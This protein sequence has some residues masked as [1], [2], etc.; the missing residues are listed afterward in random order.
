MCQHLSKRAKNSC[1]A[2][3]NS[4]FVMGWSDC[5]HQETF[6]FPVTHLIQYCASRC[7]TVSMQSSKLAASLDIQ[8]GEAIPGPLMRN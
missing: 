5:C 8:Q 2:I 4:R 1:Y 6:F 7:Y 3:S